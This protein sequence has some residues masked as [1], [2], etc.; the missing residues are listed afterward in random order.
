MPLIRYSK[1]RIGP[2]RLLIID[3]AN[4][5]LEDYAAQGFDMTL[6]QLYYQF[7][8]HDYF[9]DSRIDRKYNREHGLDPDTKNTAKNYTWLGDIIS[10]GRLCGLVDWEQIEDRTRNL[11]SRSSWDTTRDMLDTAYYGYHRSR[12]ENQPCRLEVWCEKEALIGI[13][14][15]VC[16]K[17]DIP[18][19]A[20]RGYVSLSEMWVAAQRL[21]EYAEDGQDPIIIHFGDHDPSGVDMTRD[22]GARLETFEVSVDVRRVALNMDQVQQYQPPPNPAKM[23]DARAKRYIAKYGKKSWE[24]DALNPSM[25]IS[26][27]EDV[28]EE[29]RD[30][31][32]WGE[33]I[34][35]EIE[36][37]AHLRTLREQWVGI[38]KKLSKEILKLSRTIVD[39]ERKYADERSL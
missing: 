15:S 10:D 3:K 27:V 13:F 34:D 31:D 30:E 37:R 23:T 26:L 22:I 18:Y 19:F 24:L 17:W 25:L 8:A 12:W 29:V 39:K 20:C 6:R 4:E 5:I 16:R 36:D 28:V 38:D 35:R 7:I 14:D 32:L 1:K 9:P 2:G 21:Q 11:E 33:V